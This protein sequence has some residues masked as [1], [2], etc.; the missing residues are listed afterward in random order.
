ME[1]I[2]QSNLEEVFFMD[3]SFRKI[4]NDF[5][6]EYSQKICPIPNIQDIQLISDDKI[7]G[8]FHADDLYNRIYFISK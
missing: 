8:Y 7:G 6:D 3:E 2:L 4:L 1:R 5:I